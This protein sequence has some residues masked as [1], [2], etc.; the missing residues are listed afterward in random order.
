MRK[1]G[2]LPSASEDRTKFKTPT[3]HSDGKEKPH[4]GKERGCV[5]TPQN[6]ILTA[7]FCSLSIR[8]FL[9]TGFPIYPETPSVGVELICAIQA[10]QLR[11]KTRDPYPK[12]V[13]CQNFHVERTD[14]LE[15]KLLPR[16]SIQTGALS[17]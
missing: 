5:C 16:P 11:T 8:E 1:R 3:H 4:K 13:V 2:R 6:I 7:L 9:K 17:P 10:V 14:D 12:K 15:P